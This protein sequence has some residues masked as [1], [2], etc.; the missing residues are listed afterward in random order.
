MARS[1]GIVEFK[2]YEAD[3]FLERLCESTVNNFSWGEAKFFLSAFIS[4]TRSITFTLQASIK[5]SKELEDWYLEKQETLKKDKEA[6][7]FLEVRNL[8]QK[9]GYCPITG[10]KITT[11]ING[12]REI[13]L[14]F[15]IQ[16]QENLKFIP[17][18]DV[19][20][21]C[22]SFFKTILTIVQECYVK[23]GY[24]IDSLKYFTVENMKRLDKSVEDLEE[25][26]GF[27]RGWTNIPN[28]SQEERMENLLNHFRNTETDN[29]I[30]IIFAKHLGEDRFGKKI[31]NFKKKKRDLKPTK[32]TEL[33]LFVDLLRKRN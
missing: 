5:G 9:I 31:K 8:N 13:L 23:F 27:P 16:N 1:F 10:G 28:I 25:E 29:S 19:I 3:F 15:D 6:R 12:R 33:D 32:T 17:E 11:D 24:I 30:D 7:F 22:E 4:A 2:I 18:D 14:Y 21:V 26:M 20:T